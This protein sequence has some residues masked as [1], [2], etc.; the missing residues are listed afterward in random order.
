MGGDAGKGATARS[1]LDV[2]GLG[3][4]REAFGLL[5]R[6]HLGTNDG[7]A[8]I[9]WRRLTAQGCAKKAVLGGD[10]AVDAMQVGE[11][12]VVGNVLLDILVVQT[13]QLLCRHEADGRC[14]LA[15][16][17]TRS[18]RTRSGAGRS[19]LSKAIVKGIF[20]EVVR[21]VVVATAAI[22]WERLVVDDGVQVEI[23]VM[24]AI[25]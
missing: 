10:A 19:S 14:E 2:A 15:F 23:G 12:D 4:G 11:D 7:E 16:G 13:R 3:G 17:E 22:G 6:G 18:T 5:P 21:L 9:R 8:S 20:V 25:S 24:D 1:A